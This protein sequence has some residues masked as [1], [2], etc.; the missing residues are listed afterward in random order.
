MHA[1]PRTMR[2]AAERAALKADRKAQKAGLSTAD[3]TPTPTPKPSLPITTPAPKTASPA[4]FAA[5]R[6]NSQFS[7]GPTTSEGKAIS[8][9]NHTQHGLTVL[10]SAGP[11]AVLA[12]EDQSIYDN[13]LDALKQEW[14]P[15]TTTEL[16]LVEKLATH[17]WLRRRASRLQD[18]RIEKGMNEMQDYKQFEVFARYHTTHMRAANKALADLMRIRNFQMRQL[19][20]EAMLERRAQDAQ[21]RFESQKR[22]AEEYAAKMETIRLKQEAQKQRNAREADSSRKSGDHQRG[23]VAESPLTQAA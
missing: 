5:N 9:R 22:K 3:P 20:D 12:T 23:K 1:S 18:E 16:D 14:H 13:F 17:T 11:F 15:A 21:I 4:Q 19:K 2:R 7:C 6:A 10:V 8:S